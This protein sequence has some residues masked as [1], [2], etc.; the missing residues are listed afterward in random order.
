MKTDNLRLTKDIF[1]EEGKKVEA[2][3]AKDLKAFLGESCFITSADKQSDMMRHIDLFCI[4]KG[5]KFTVDVKAMKRERR[6]EGVKKDIQ[7]VEFQNGDGYTGWVCGKQTH[8]A[9]E[10]PT[11]WLVVPRTRL[12][13]ETL[14]RMKSLKTITQDNPDFYMFYR[15]KGRFDLVVKVPFSMI[16]EN[17][18][19]FFVPKRQDLN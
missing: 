1:L 18:K 19:G 6:N 17:C 5:N 14:K 15:R 4:Y 7:W 13:N 16:E 8:I 9:F 3:F 12:K 11:G 2:E 10:T